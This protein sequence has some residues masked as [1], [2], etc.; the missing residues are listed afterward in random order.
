MSRGEP[1]EA[2]DSAPPWSPG[3][4]RPW[5]PLAGR[6]RFRSVEACEREDWTLAVWRRDGEG[7]AKLS[8]LLC[9]SWRCRRCAA[10]RGAVDW[11][12]VSKGVTSRSWWLYLVLTFDPRD[13]SD[14]FE[15]F[16]GAGQAWDHNLRRWI[17]RRCGRQ[18][19]VQ[20]W[21]RHASGWPHCNVLVSSAGL[22][23]D[24]DA[25][26]VVVRRHG[27]TGRSCKFS[28]AWRQAFGQAA[29]RAGFGRAV[30]TEIIDQRA[31]GEAMSNYLLKLAKEL[32]GATSK[33]G[34]Q[35]PVN[36]P[37]HFRRIRA[38][39]GLLPPAAK[40]SGEWT[41]QLL[42][43]P[44]ART[45]RILATG[46]VDPGPRRPG[47]R[48]AGIALPRADLE[49]LLEARAKSIAAAWSSGLEVA[50]APRYDDAADYARDPQNE[51]SGTW[52]APAFD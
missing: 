2:S 46:E 16:R 13:W 47:G 50:P 28:P 44:E 32:T 39:R 34:G 21:E 27:K 8:P 24:L 3:C 9:G 23:A 25:A 7:D 33:K 52:T 40:S 30:W 37:R 42:T 4:D 31:G 19:Y 29:V 22:E 51:F 12:R 1:S 36:A 26:G 35:S 18:A 17:E 20:T 15:A 6:A 45:R 48:P 41:G 11:S 43:L 38:S 5:S 49:T 14:K 10:W